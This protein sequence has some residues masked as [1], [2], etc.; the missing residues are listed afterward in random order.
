M[1]CCCSE[2]R[3]VGSFFRLH[4]FF[5]HFGQ[6]RVDRLPPRPVRET[7]DAAARPPAC[8]SGRLRHQVIHHL[9]NLQENINKP[10]TVT[11][12]VSV[13]SRTNAALTHHHRTTVN[14][15]ATT[16]EQLSER[17]CE[18]GQNTSVDVDVKVSEIAHMSR[19]TCT[20]MYVTNMKSKALK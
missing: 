4:F 9:V 1:S 11:H 20:Y 10:N 3:L 17:I 19:C 12:S 6:K 13:T 5:I 16:A 15:T 7:H 2:R 14:S 18:V 8:V